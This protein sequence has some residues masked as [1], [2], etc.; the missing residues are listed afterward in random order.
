M[1]RVEVIIACHSDR[2]RLDRP[3][4]LPRRDARAGD[5]QPVPVVELEALQ[6]A[7]QLQQSLPPGVELGL[8]VV[9]QAADAAARVIH[10]D[11]VVR[12]LSRQPETLELA[13]DPLRLAQRPVHR[14]PA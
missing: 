1:K 9:E 8:L 11:H 6:G 12:R 5:L 14:A 3:H 7:A 10:P 4:L 13:Q 2:R